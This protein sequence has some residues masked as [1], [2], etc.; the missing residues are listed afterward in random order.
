MP[1][2]FAHAL[3]LATSLSLA[4][5]SVAQERDANTLAQ[6]L[7]NPATS[8]ASLSFKFDYRIYDGALPGADAQEGF[9][10]TFQPVLPFELDDGDK[11]IFRPAFSF[12]VDEP[13]FDASRGAF[14]D[15]GGIGDFGFD[16]AYAPKTDGKFSYGLGVLGGLPTGT[17]RR[18]RSGNWTLG[19]EFFGA[20]V[21]TWG[22]VGGLA[23]HSW[24]VAGHGADVSLS[25]LQYFLFF[26]LGDGWQVGAGPTITYDWNGQP[27]DR[28]NVPVGLGVSKTTKLF[29][30][31]I[32][33]NTELD[34][35]IIRQDTFGAEWL[36]KFS[37]TP[38]IANPFD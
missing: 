1:T 30:M 7:S 35:S 8:L 24:K 20:Y 19:P 22:I 23:S 13:F 2:R 12:P 28:W 14:D 26:S 25:S 9:T 10:F 15:S 36:V 3:I 18:L 29:G 5:T 4:T 16:L 37:I 33:F 34:Y 38:V 21:D 32:K 31:P 17:N 6:E 11:V 27:G